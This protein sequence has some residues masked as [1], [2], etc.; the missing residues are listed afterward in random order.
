MASFGET[1]VGGDEKHGAKGSQYHRLVS[2]D[3]KASEV[4]GVR[5]VLA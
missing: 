4:P 1:G 3:T 5:S 2:I